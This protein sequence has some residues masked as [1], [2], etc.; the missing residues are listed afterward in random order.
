MTN[1]P[2]STGYVAEHYVGASAAARSLGISVRRLKQLR[3]RGELPVVWTP[4]GRLYRRDDLER[5]TA[6]RSARGLGHGA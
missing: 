2:D 4:L 3:D 1:L 5:L 6:E